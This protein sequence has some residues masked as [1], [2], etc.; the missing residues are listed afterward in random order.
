MGSGGERSSLPDTFKQACGEREMRPFGAR[1]GRRESEIVSQAEK[2]SKLGERPQWIQR[3]DSGWCGMSNSKNCC[4]E[5]TGIR[6]KRWPCSCWEW[7][8]QAVLVCND[9]QKRCMSVV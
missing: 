7:S 8:C 3:R 6:K 2:H 4:Q 5:S 9:S 1:R